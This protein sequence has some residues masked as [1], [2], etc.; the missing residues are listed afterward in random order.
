MSGCWLH[1]TLAHTHIHPHIQNE[2]ENY[3]RVESFKI[4]ALHLTS[5]HILSG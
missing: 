4:V 2:L 3:I 1:H 5:Q